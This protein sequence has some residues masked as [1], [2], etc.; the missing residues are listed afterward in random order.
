MTTFSRWISLIDIVLGT[1]GGHGGGPRDLF[2]TKVVGWWT[3]V[4][5]AHRSSLDGR[6][7]HR[8]LANALGTLVWPLQCHW[9]TWGPWVVLQ[10]SY[11]HEIW[12][13]FW[14]NIKF[15]GVQQLCLGEIFSILM[16]VCAWKHRLRPSMLTQSKA[17]LLWVLED[18]HVCLFERQILGPTSTRDMSVTDTLHPVCTCGCT[19]SQTTRTCRLIYM[20]CRNI[21]PLMH[22]WKLYRFLI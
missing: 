10:P 13:I 20:Q 11:V 15:N 2:G 18:K 7:S 3:Y 4:C 9:R 8:S 16:Q 14:A 1:R 5:P 17:L 19:N 21:L 22:S 6:S 12:N